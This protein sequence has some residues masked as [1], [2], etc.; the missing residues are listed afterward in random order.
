M[1]Q[2]AVVVD[3]DIVDGGQAVVVIV[4]DARIVVVDDGVDGVGVG[5]VGVD[6]VDVGVFA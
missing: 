6:G 3:T 1:Q 5:G 2:L 4:N